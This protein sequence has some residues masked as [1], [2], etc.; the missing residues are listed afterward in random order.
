MDSHLGK[1]ATIENIRISPQDITD[2]LLDL[3]QKHAKC[4][5]LIPEYNER[6]SYYDAEILDRY[7]VQINTAAR[8]LLEFAY[9]DRLGIQA[10]FDE[11]GIQSAIG[12]TSKEMA[13]SVTE[14]IFQ[15]AVIKFLKKKHENDSIEQILEI[16]KIFAEIRP[17]IITILS[18][19][20]T[21]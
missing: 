11:N 18:K 8:V 6:G 14:M 16:R 5:E 20:N 19:F 21:P 9:D 2:Y 4:C 12:F 15:R 10:L 1:Y 13:M 7:A 17:H 3:E